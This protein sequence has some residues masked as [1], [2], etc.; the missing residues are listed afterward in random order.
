MEVFRNDGHLTDQALRRLAAGE[1]L[2]ELTRLELAEH[3]S[4]CDQCLERYTAL[5]ERH[6]VL[7]EPSPQC[8]QSLFRHIRLQ[9]ARVFVNRYAAAAAAVALALTMV[10]SGGPEDWLRLPD[11]PGEQP[12]VT[13]HFRDWT[14][15]WNDSLNRAVAGVNDLFDGLG[16]S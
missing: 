12:I 11:P 15:R 9:A 7:L 5:L 8:R 14:D 13:E 4:F 3:L 2:P 1:E 10:W 16:L 6:T